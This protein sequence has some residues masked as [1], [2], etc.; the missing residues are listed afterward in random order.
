MF[1]LHNN[2]SALELYGAA[3]LVQEGELL[4]LSDIVSSYSGEGY[5][6]GTMQLAIPYSWEFPSI[7][8]SKEIRSVI[9]GVLEQ[10]F[11]F[12]GG[13]LLF[14]PG[15]FSVSNNAQFLIE[16]LK[17][18]NNQIDASG[19][20]IELESVDGLPERMSS[21]NIDFKM[22]SSRRSLISGRN[23]VLYKMPEMEQY[24]R[25]TVT[26]RFLKQVYVATQSILSDSLLSDDL[27]IIDYR[28][29][30]KTK[31]EL[32]DPSVILSSYYTVKD[33]SNGDILLRTD[34]KREFDVFAGNEVS[35]IL[36]YGPIQMTMAG[37]LLQSGNLGE[38]IQARM[39][40]TG[41]KI[42]GILRSAEVVYV[43][44]Q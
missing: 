33:I 7:I 9:S 26:V 23:S 5:I 4:T 32:F 14:V 19:V 30:R 20:R 1:S 3:E 43:E 10:P 36:E 24:R 40:Q 13:A 38:M 28:D 2:I 12:V 44:I 11:T 25:L 22:A 29:T 8:S 27:V 41:K 35:V 31:S 34:V 6:R 21:K 42:D 17:F 15:R 39:Y 18:C 37:Y 16:L